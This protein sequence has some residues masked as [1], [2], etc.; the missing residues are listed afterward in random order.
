MDVFE[1]KVKKFFELFLHV[2]NLNV[3]LLNGMLALRFD[4]LHVLPQPG[5]FIV[6]LLSHFFNPIFYHCLNVL[7]FIDNLFETS[8]L[9]LVVFF[10]LVKL[11][12]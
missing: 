11:S 7:L 3:F 8:D 10:L 12:F 5:D 6:L 9:E 1:L 4:V 2:F